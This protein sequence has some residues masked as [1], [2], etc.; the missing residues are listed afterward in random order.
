MSNTV[1]LAE[2]FANSGNFK[3]LF[4]DGMSLV[5]ETATYLDGKGRDEAKGLPRSSAM[6]Y[7]SESMR[8]TTRLMQIASWLLLQRAAN[9]GEMTRDQL[10]EEKKKI[11][12][13]TVNDQIDNPGWKDMPVEFLE[14]VSRSLTMQNR[15]MRLD[16]ELYGHKVE[17]PVDSN[18]PVG[19]QIDLLSTALGAA[20]QSK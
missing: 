12:L 4:Q 16:A 2:R 7:G 17:E 13:E 8:L 1:N 18:N 3:A 19:Q 20:K 10:L 14:L 11:K 9:E 15:V 5:E 6:L